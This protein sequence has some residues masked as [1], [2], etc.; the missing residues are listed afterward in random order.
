MKTLKPTTP[1]RRQMTLVDRSIL[2]ERKGE[3]SLLR[4]KISRAGRS[5]KGS[6]TVRRRGGGHKRKYRFVDFK[7]E[8]FDI[9]GVVKS[10]EY[11]PNR[12][13]YIVLICYKDGE[14]R[15]VLAPEG[16]KVG[17][18]IMSSQKKIERRV[19]SRLL[20]K[21]IPLSSFVY[22]IEMSPGGGGKMV[23]SAG[24]YAILQARENGFAQLEMSSGEVRLVPENC[25][26]SIGQV[27][28]IEHG[29]VKIG[30]AGRSRW[31]GIR[32]HVRGKA[33]VPKDH[34]HGGGEGGSPI[35][36][37]HPKTKWGKPAF[38]VRT[39]KKHKKSNRLILKRRK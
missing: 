27:S 14:K 8:K 28:N 39:R 11:D 13:A 4:G 9:P 33:M 21:H 29:A 23:R 35:G 31:L 22:N 1:G 16:I 15:Y 37:K 10:V 34:P 7:R 36:L 30:K 24:S 3:K 17:D 20:L 6:I 38:G 2:S 19:G 18:E 26:A 32:P 25:M 5:R 12:S